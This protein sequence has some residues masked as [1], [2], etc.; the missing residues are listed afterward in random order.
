[1]AK[2][3]GVGGSDGGQT[4]TGR[5]KD[6]AGGTGPACAKAV[7]DVTYAYGAPIVTV[8]KERGTAAVGKGNPRCSACTKVGAGQ[9]YV[10]CRG[11]AADGAYGSDV[12]IGVRKTNAQSVYNNYFFSMSPILPQELRRGPLTPTPRKNRTTPKK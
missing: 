10:G 5:S 9:L 12:I 2:Y 6:A 7:E 4:A 3:S 1:M 8:G 11:V